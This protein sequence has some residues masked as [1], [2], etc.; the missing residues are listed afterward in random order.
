MRLITLITS[1]IYIL[2]SNNFAQAHSKFFDLAEVKNWR[3][4]TE[5]DGNK[6]ICHA[7]MTPYRNK[8]LIGNINN[9]KFIVS[10]KGHLSYSISF[11]ASSTLS[12]SRNVKLFIND[13]EYTLKVGNHGQNAITYS[14]EQD[15]NIINNLISGPYIFKIKSKSSDG[16]LGIIYFSSLGLQEAIAY[17]EKHCS[18]KP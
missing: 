16:D 17:M 7:I 3:I 9:P 1:L 15:I 12:P 6:K 5:L 18:K 14:S 11:S 2:I 4:I 10:Y 13:T 8:Q